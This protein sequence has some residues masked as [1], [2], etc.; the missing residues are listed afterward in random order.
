MILQAPKKI[1]PLKL[2]KSIFH[3]NIN[4][5]KVN[6]KN[7][8]NFKGQAKKIQYGTDMNATHLPV[9]WQLRGQCQV[10]R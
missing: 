8:V 7:K 6:H 1:P 9:L 4:L 2:N 10:A 5:Y 3:S